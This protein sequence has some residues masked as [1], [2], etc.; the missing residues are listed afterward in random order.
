MLSETQP[1]NLIQQ[2]LVQTAGELLILCV[3]K[4]NFQVCQ[5]LAPFAQQE[6]LLEDHRKAVTAKRKRER[7]RERYYLPNPSL[8]MCR[9][10]VKVQSPNISGKKVTP[11]GAALKA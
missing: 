5:H 6:I 1:E 11:L 10:L 7:E 4:R 2:G 8:M 9:R 3:A